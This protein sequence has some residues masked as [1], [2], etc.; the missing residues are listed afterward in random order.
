MNKL[1]NQLLSFFLS[2]G[3]I[4]FL[5]ILYMFLSKEIFPTGQEKG[6]RLKIESVRFIKNDL[7]N[8]KLLDS[9]NIN[10]EV[11]NHFQNELYKSTCNIQIIDSN[12]NAIYA[13][14]NDFKLEFIDPPQSIDFNSNSLIPQ[15]VLK[16]AFKL[17]IEFK[18]KKR[19]EFPMN[20]FYETLGL[21]TKDNYSTDQR[22]IKLI[23]N[24]NKIELFLVLT[25]N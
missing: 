2:F 24:D 13:K 23:S 11:N 1:N 20:T 5:V 19:I 21:R 15:Y 16:D 3:I 22:E 7:F 6:H 25:I 10:S 8:H 12:D 4:F 17:V 14:S 9:L 18:D